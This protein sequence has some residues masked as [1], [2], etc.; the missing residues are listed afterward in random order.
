MLR[1]GYNYNIQRVSFN[2]KN[3]IEYEWLKV[4][5]DIWNEIP[6]LENKDIQLLTGISSLIINSTNNPYVNILVDNKDI[7]LISSEYNVNG[8]NDNKLDNHLYLDIESMAYITTKTGHWFIVKVDMIELFDSV[9][10]FYNKSGHPKIYGFIN[11]NNRL[12]VLY[13]IDKNII[14]TIPNYEIDLFRSDNIIT[15]N[16]TNIIN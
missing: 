4:R 7:K 16:T 9:Y 1:I 14:Q 8:N 3:P 15:I 6:L 11:R 2:S 10:K 5:N 13:K 12:L